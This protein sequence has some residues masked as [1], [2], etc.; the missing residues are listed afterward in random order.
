M[1]S[2]IF[3]NIV[4]AGTEADDEFHRDL[5]VA[6]D[7]GPN[8]TAVVLGR[9][10]V[11]PP[12]IAVAAVEAFGPMPS[13]RDAAVAMGH[14]FRRIPRAGIYLL[15]EQMLQNVYTPMM[16]AA[17]SAI[18]TA[19]VPGALVIHVPPSRMTKVFGLVS[20]DHDERKK[21]AVDV[22]WKLIHDR[23]ATNTSEGFIEYVTD[24]QR[25]HDVADALLLFVWYARRGKKEIERPLAGVLVIRATDPHNKTAERRRIKDRVVKRKIA[26]AALK[27]KKKPAPGNPPPPKKRRK[28]SAIK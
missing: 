13:A 25:S 28:V 7:F 21:S 18:A 22:M 23:E 6:I 12:Q 11:N 14:L 10:Y 26:E 3:P 27:K 9:P 24:L 17:F 15:E 16:E 2:E 19:T 5:A 4:S 8:A 1:A 20:G